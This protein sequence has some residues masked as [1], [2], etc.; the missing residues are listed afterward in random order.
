MALVERDPRVRAASAELD[1]ANF[2]RQMFQRLITPPLTLGADYGRQTRD[3]PSGA[4]SGSPLAGPLRANWTDAELVFNVSI[5]LPLFNRQ[6]ES[7]ARA[8]GR[9]LAA[10]AT[11]RVARANVRTELES[12]WAAW[13]AAARAQQRVAATTAIIDRDVAFVEQAVTAGA[14]DTLTRT[15]ELRRLQDAG[16]RVDTAVRDV[17]AARAAWLRRIAG[18]P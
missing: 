15:L 14:F 7:R 5:G 6:R 18:G 8:T 10:D 1:A 13:Q 3:I 17:R 4:F 2:E 12:S 16:R 11:L 9:M